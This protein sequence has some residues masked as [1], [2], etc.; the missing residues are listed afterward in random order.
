MTISLQETVAGGDVIIAGTYVA[1]PPSAAVLH[2]LPPPPRDFTGRTAE[3]TELAAVVRSGG[4]SILGLCGMGGVGKTAFALTLAAQLMPDY[5][6]AQLYLDL[7]GASDQPMSR[8]DALAH[9]VRAFLPTGAIPEDEGVLSGCYRSLLCGKRVLLL[10]DNAANEDQVLPLILGSGCLLLV[11]SRSHVVV[12]GMVCRRVDTLPRAEAR[13][14][15]LKI[16]PGMSETAEAVAEM[17]G[18][19]PLALRAAA[20]LV[21]VS[22]DL[23]PA[24]YAQELVDEKTRLQRLGTEGVDASVEAAFDLSYRRLDPVSA[25][26][27]RALAVFP[28]SFNGETAEMVGPDPGRVRLR[29]LVRRSLVQWDPAT[30]RYRLH[31][32]LRVFAETRLP[33]EERGAAC[34]RLASAMLQLVETA[35]PELLGSQQDAWLH[36]LE[37]EQQNL[38]EALDWS[39]GPDAARLADEEPPAAGAEAGASAPL[40]LTTLAVRL[41]GSLWRFW[42]IRGYLREGEERLTAVLARIPEDASPGERAKALTGAGILAYFRGDHA[43]AAFLCQDGL[44]LCRDAG[45]RWSLALS[46][47]ILGIYGEY[48]PIAGA[49]AASQAQFQESLTLAHD[50][51]DPW[52]TA[53]AQGEL[54][55]FVLHS[56]DAAYALDLC[57]EGLALARQ[58][59]N[60]WLLGVSLGNTAFCLLHQCQPEAAATLF[61]ESLGV[62]WELRDQVGITVCLGGLAG[63]AVLQGQAERAGRLFGAA[64]A[65]ITSIEAELP[66]VFRQGYESMAAEARDRFGSDGFEAAWQAGQTMPLSD[67]VTAALAT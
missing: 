47:L 30:R 61:R 67:A 65:L 64:T 33:D 40:R 45:D 66:P 9:M 14:L 34:T 51:G 39:L 8:I 16:A 27:F 24:A 25:G 23:D 38:R 54:G 15:L 41:A 46:L 4:A 60:H 18:D 6:D 57:R 59:G 36:L 50:L 52:L 53:L 5:P 32:L 42:V 55:L 13:N 17:C 12:P 58:V 26:I 2:Q 29:D 10:L 63:V 3:L 56:G 35:E 48:Y 19:L 28:S 31:D 20:S 22:E 7:R 44:S 1:A 49:Q 37:L 62:R 11:T 43:R 21:A